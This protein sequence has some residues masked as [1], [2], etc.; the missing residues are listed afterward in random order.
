MLATASLCPFGLCR[1]REHTIGQNSKWRVGAVVKGTGGTTKYF[2]QQCR[3]WAAYMVDRQCEPTVGVDRSIPM[4]I[5]NIPN[6][7]FAALLNL[8]Q[9]GGTRHSQIH[10]QNLRA[11]QSPK[12]FGMDAKIH[13]MTQLTT[14]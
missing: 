5:F 14:T 10:T 2:E 1:G 6:S 12:A 7:H 9:G 11:P 8:H 13:P 4:P 3:V